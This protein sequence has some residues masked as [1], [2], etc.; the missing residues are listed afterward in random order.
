[1]CEGSEN[2]ILFGSGLEA[3]VTDLGGGIDELKINLLGLPGLG[4]GEDRLADD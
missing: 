4:G 1:V 2:L 3:T